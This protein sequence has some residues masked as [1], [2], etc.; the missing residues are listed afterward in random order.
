MVNLT[1]GENSAD[2]LY[3]ANHGFLDQLPT[4]F[5]ESLNI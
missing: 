3:E 5:D 1:S 4:A 2:G